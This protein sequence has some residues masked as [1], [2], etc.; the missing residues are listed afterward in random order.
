MTISDMLEEPL[1]R[2][3]DLGDIEILNITDNNIPEDRYDIVLEC[4]GATPAVT[5]AFKAVNIGGTIIQVGNL[6][7]ESSPIN[8]SPINIKQATYRGC[9]RF[10]REIEDALTVLAKNEKIINVITQ[11]Y[12]IENFREAFEIAANSRL[13]SKVMIKL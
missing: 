5:T 7:D 1:A 2:A 8:L 6:Q 10:N 3:H 9:Y 11:T 4:S 12:D 13:S